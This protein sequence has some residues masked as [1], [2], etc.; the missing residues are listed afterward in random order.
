MTQNKK[1]LKELYYSLTPVERAKVVMSLRG[2][3]RPDQE[4]AL[5]RLGRPSEICGKAPP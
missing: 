3:L 2:R 4:K 5:L 1:L